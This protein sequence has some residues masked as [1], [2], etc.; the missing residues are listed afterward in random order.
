MSQVLNTISDNNRMILETDEVLPQNE[1]SSVVSAGLRQL[2]TQR[3]LVYTL[4]S[5]QG[6][7]TEEVADQLQISVMDVKGQYYH[8]CRFLRDYSRQQAGVQAMRAVMTTFCCN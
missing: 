7:S 5:E 4:R 1:Y 6:L 2:S 8:A 3:R